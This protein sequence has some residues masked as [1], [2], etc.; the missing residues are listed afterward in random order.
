LVFVVFVV[1]FASCFCL[2]VCLFVF[3]KKQKKTKKQQ[4]QKNKK[5]KKTK[6][7][8]SK[9]CE[10]RY[11]GWFSSSCS[12]SQNLTASHEWEKTGCDYD[13]GSLGRFSRQTYN[14]TIYVWNVYVLRND[15]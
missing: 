12:A 10:F 7:N 15:G 2:F 4:K 6:Q 13:K 5:Q 8:K 9:G 11:L 3:N 14:W 1:F